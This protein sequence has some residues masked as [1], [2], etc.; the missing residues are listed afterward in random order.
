M[1]KLGSILLSALFVFGSG[2]PALANSAQRYFEGVSPVGTM[3]TGEQSPIV[4]ERED[5]T[6]DLQEFPL[7]WYDELEKYLAYNGKVT[8]EYTFYNPTDYDVTATLVFPFGQTP[9]YGYR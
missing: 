7:D 9:D 2:T 6:F 1:K 4:V 3:V 8:A 5:L